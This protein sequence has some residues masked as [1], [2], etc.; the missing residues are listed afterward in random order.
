MFGK[1]S[2]SKVKLKRSYLLYL[3]LLLLLLLILGR[4]VSF[5]ASLSIVSGDSMLPALRSGDLVLGVSSD[6][7]VGDV[8]IWYATFMHGTIHRVVNVT[9]DYVV[10]KGDNNPLPD[11]PIPKSFVKY[12]VVLI[13]PREIWLSLVIVSVIVYVY[14]KR[15]GM[16]EAL[17]SVA[18]GEL[19]LVYLIFITFMLINLLTLLLVSI[20]YNSPLSSL[21][22]PSVE[23]R[24]ITVID[25]GKTII[26]NYLQNNVQALNVRL[27]EVSVFNVS[28]A[29]TCYLSGSTISV[30]IPP[31]AY[32]VA[33][34]LSNSTITNISVR[35]NVTLD[36]GYVYGTY[37]YTINWKPLIVTVSNRSVNVYNPNYIPFN[38]T[39]IKITYIKIKPPFN[40]PEVIKTVSL[41]NMTVNAMSNATIRVEQLGSYAYVE[42][43]YDFKFR[44]VVLERKYVEG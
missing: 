40:T 6:Y 15:E 9:S 19:K 13:I 26:I 31:E 38:L 3:F 43:T 16:I 11:P 36:K 25:N 37:S 24:G 34:K 14:Y 32:M 10:T 29:T 12:K 20:P 1:I 30:V 5:P 7:K 35:L 22:T 39:N 42:F 41:G 18:P 44:G 23:L 21:I 8:V 4:L 2:V 27:C 17:K 33:Y 28:F